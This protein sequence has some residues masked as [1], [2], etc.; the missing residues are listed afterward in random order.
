VNDLK[1]IVKQFKEVQIEAD[2]SVLSIDIQKALPHLCNAIDMI[3]R[4]FLR[5]Q[6]EYL[7]A[8]YDDIMESEEENRKKF[9]EL[10]KGPYNPLTNYKSEFGDV[11]NR[12]KGCAFYPDTLED[13]RIIDKI[14]LLDEED[15]KMAKD[16]YTIIR[17][18]EVGLEIIPYHIYYASELGEIFDELEIAADLIENE[19]LSTY[20]I[21]KAEALIS[22]SYRDS[23]CEWVRLKESPLDLVIGP[24]EVYADALLGIK[25]TYESMLMIVDFKKGAAL[26]EIENNLDKLAEVF[27]LPAE[28]KG[29]MGGM[30]PIVVVNQIYSGG[31]AAQGVMA[32]AFNLPND[33]WVRGNVGWKQVMLYNV[34]KAKFTAVTTE[35]AK[36][37]LHGGDNVDFEPFFTFVLLH[38]ISHGLGP[39]YRKDGI[40]V[41]KSIGSSYVAIEE[42]K[43]DTGA[44]FLILKLGGQYG[45]EKYNDEVL[46][47]TYLAGLFRSMRFGVH[48]A[49]G[50][51]NLIQFNWLWEKGII[52]IEGDKF[53]IK[54][55]HILETAEALLEKICSIEAAATIE[56]TEAFLEKYGKP[57][58]EVLKALD[59]LVDIPTDIKAIFPL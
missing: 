55:G 56:E 39:A 28:S 27:P 32:A 38:E 12:R 25:A 7:P 5:Q 49:H 44:L 10:F 30:A 57:G 22:G 48:E 31:E 13:C 47:K 18:M 42:T 21:N 29:A 58:D 52:S 24:Y 2:L 4:I 40:E 37:I 9:Y 35:I 17:D 8:H 26:K 33:A 51:S 11:K 54:V 23:D 15:K 16:H 45:I 34:M 3:T 14:E 59:S 53:S 46:L 36:K 1:K 41:A 20:L 19:E 43:A 50:M 6:H